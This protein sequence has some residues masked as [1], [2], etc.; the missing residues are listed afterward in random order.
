MLTL[1]PWPVAQR[2]KERRSQPSNIFGEHQAVARAHTSGLLSQVVRRLGGSESAILTSRSSC[3]GCKALPQYPS[4]LAKRTFIG[5]AHRWL[6]LIIHHGRI[7]VHL[8]WPLPHFEHLL[9][10]CVAFVDDPAVLQSDRKLG[11]APTSLA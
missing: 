4:L 5:E 10:L 8:L 2:K 9:H 7:L 3:K 6:C 1:E 11:A